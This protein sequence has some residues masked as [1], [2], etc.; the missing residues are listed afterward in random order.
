MT[1]QGRFILMT[2][3][4]I[5]LCQD[6]EYTLR[7]CSTNFSY[8]ANTSLFE[9]NILRIKSLASEQLFVIHKQSSRPFNEEEQSKNFPR[10]LMAIESA[11]NAL[12]IY[13]SDNFD[14]SGQ[15]IYGIALQNF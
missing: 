15:N 10:L 6:Y 4:N 3:V 7:I 8:I 13:N 2:A 11:K 12:S 9:G 14:T 5:F 1:I